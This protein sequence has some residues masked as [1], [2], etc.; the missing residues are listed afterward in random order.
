MTGKELI[1]SLLDATREDP[2]RGV[3]TL[4]GAPQMGK[5]YT[6]G[7]YNKARNMPGI[8]V[9]AQNTPEEELAGYPMRDEKK[10]S[11][12]YSD[13][14]ALTTMLDSMGIDGASPYT[15]FM[16]ELDKPDRAK[17]NILLT[18]FNPDERRLRHFVMHKDIL[19]CA[20]MNPPTAPLPE[21][22]VA[23]LLFVPYPVFNSEALS[24]LPSTVQHI[25]TAT[26]SLEEVAFPARKV[27]KGAFFKLEK[28]FSF[29]LFW[30]EEQVRQAVV[31]GLFPEQSCPRI[32]EM[33]ADR[34]VVRDPTEWV[35][36]ARPQAL[37]AGFIKYASECEGVDAKTKFLEILVERAE[38]DK[39]GEVSRLYEAIL[40]CG[41]AIDAVGRLGETDRA[42]RAQL[43]LEK[44]VQELGGIKG[45]SASLTKITKGDKE[46]VPRKGPS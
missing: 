41:E 21:P 36:V 18:L 26:L 45:K 42:E 44:K 46:K 28:W 20:A 11:V 9:N 30:E 17:L 33:L 12:F 3:I 25:A 32:L 37:M 43:A 35:R 2:K 24:D 8:I 23:R 13:P 19:L 5:T 29:H 22:L 31:R 1:F 4:I 34:P 27:T 40:Q 10:R 39:T 6:V 14:P 15:L 16:D 7:E 38:N